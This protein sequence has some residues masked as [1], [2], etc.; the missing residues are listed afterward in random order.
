MLICEHMFIISNT[1]KN[2]DEYITTP[3]QFNV[4][5]FIIP[6]KIC[7]YFFYY[8]CKIIIFSDANPITCSI[9]LYIFT[10]VLFIM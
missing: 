7:S 2:K 8:L 4:Q 10:T 5:I 3:V 6:F 1:L 9:I